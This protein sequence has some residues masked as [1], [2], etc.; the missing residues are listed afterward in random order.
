MRR[1]DLSDADDTRIHVCRYTSITAIEQIR[2]HNLISKAVR[3]WRDG[4]G[5]KIKVLKEKSSKKAVVPYTV[6]VQLNKERITWGGIE[7]NAIK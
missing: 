6:R 2:N 7:V 3:L 5:Q 4:A 1:C